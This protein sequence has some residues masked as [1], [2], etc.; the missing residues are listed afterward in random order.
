MIK[1]LVPGLM[2]VSGC[3]ELEVE[4]Q[5]WSAEPILLTISVH[6]HNYGLDTTGDE[7]EARREE[8]Y[9]AHQTELLWLAE[10]AE[11]EGMLLSVQIN[12][13]YALDA[14][15]YDDTAHLHDL[16]DTGHELSV[17]FHRFLLEPGGS[18]WLEYEA[19]EASESWVRQTWADHVAAFEAAVGQAPLRVD[20]AT[21]IDTPAQLALLDAL[22]VEYGIEVSHNLGERLSYTPWNIKP[23]TP[24]RRAAGTY[25]GSD[26]EGQSITTSALGQISQE[27]PQGHHA[28]YSAP[29]QIRR[30]LLVLE[31][32]RRQQALSGSDEIV[33]QFGVMTHL[34]LNAANRLPVESLIREL[35]ALTR[36]DGLAE[37]ATDSL[38]LERFET[39]EA[40][41]PGE[42]AFSFDWDGWLAGDDVDLPYA[43]EGVI[44]GLKDT[45]YRRTI[46]PADG[47]N[48]VALSGRAITREPLDELGFPGEMAVGEALGPVYLLWSDRVH[49]ATIDFSPQLSGT[50]WV[51]DGASGEVTTQDA[52]HLEVKATP[53]VVTRDPALLT[54]CDL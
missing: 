4:E 38:V 27:P 30:H 42:V 18:G 40:A 43:L 50:L 46:A 2:F 49:T 5:E 37:P 44:C 52:E 53:I 32:E 15:R 14:I 33:W 51:M 6:G 1:M 26:P 19:N 54:G 29:D 48:G 35:G 31:A 11:S 3:S 17:H 9:D 7:V 22:E 39:W 28:I 8:R 41:H 13:E 45:E 47:V 34:D 24:Y 23:L 20:A 12:G 36:L 25:T 16:L 10:L 21:G